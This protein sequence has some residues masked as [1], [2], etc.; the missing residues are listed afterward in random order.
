MQV[1]EKHTYNL[2]LLKTRMENTILSKYKS[3]RV[4]AMSNNIDP[5]NVFKWTS[6]KNTT[7]PNILILFALLKSFPNL[8]IN[9]LLRSALIVD[10]NTDNRLKMV[11]E[12]AAIYGNS[13]LTDE[14]DALKKEQIK[15][16]QMENAGIKKRIKLKSKK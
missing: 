7:Q 12:P 9:D 15:L 8:N 1:A 16:L 4:F 6:P 14:I 5:T 3:V 10:S 2:K 13:T 11:A